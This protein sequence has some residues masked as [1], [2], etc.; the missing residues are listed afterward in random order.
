ME[1]TYT[2]IPHTPPIL[3][4]ENN[5]NFCTCTLFLI[6]KKVNHANCQWD[7][8]WNIHPCNA[9]NLLEAFCS[10]NTISQA[11]LE[12]VMDQLNSFT[13]FLSLRAWLPEVCYNQLCIFCHVQIESKG[14]SSCKFSR[15][16]LQVQNAD[17]AQKAG[18]KHSARCANAGSASKLWKYW[19]LQFIGL[20]P[21]LNF[22]PVF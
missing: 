2:H 14:L 17:G 6:Y 12:M 11:E 3:Y 22:M 19:G 4:S 16:W 13:F 20:S 1:K 5:G 15:G 10:S 9:W 21:S 8:W 18:A 7:G